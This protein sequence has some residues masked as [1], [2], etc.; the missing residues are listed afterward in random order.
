MR[1]SSIHIKPIL[2]TSEKHNQRIEKPN[3][4]IETG[5]INE[6]II[7][8]SVEK[9]RKKIE[10]LAKEIGKRKLQKNAEPIKEAVIVLEKH[11]S[12][13]DLKKLSIEL[14]GKFGIQVFQI[15]IHRDEGKDKDNINYHAH[16]LFDW[17]NKRTGKLI[18]LSPLD[19]VEMQTIVAKSLQMERG[20]I[21][22]KAERLEHN[23]YRKIADEK[24]KK[25]EIELEIQQ[26]KLK[27]LTEQFHTKA[28]RLAI[29]KIEVENWK[30]QYE[31]LKIE[32][33]KLERIH[34]VQ[35]FT[36]GFGM[37]F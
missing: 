27:E 25:L 20:Q 21:H 4:L 26:Q 8:D 37:G 29:M 2:S 22:S 19:I 18:R 11:H 16:L 10:F 5:Q 24:K 33:E 13:D 9:R 23:E 3:Y 34:S 12:L 6:S 14:E 31:S 36:R 17:Q 28:K 1:K 7:I 35:K 15:Y 30:N 32:A